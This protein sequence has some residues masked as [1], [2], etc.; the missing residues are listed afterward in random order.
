MKWVKQI[1]YMERH[2]F[3]VV[4]FAKDELDWYKDCYEIIATDGINDFR[5]VDFSDLFEMFGVDFGEN[6]ILVYSLTIA[7]VFLLQ[8]IQYTLTSA[9]DDCI[10]GYKVTYY[11][12]PLLFTDFRFD[13]GLELGSNLARAILRGSVGAD[14]VLSASTAGYTFDQRLE[15]HVDLDILA[16]AILLL[17]DSDES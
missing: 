4:K 1:K 7:E 6:T 5:V 8:N 12:S 11:S 13:S 15:W 3:K 2:I 14:G 17:G 16:K 10:I 9:E